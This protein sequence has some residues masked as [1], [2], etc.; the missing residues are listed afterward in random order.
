MRCQH[1]C[2]SKINKGARVLD[3][4]VLSDLAG[5]A[6]ALAVTQFAISGGE[7][8][9]FH[10]L[11]AIVNAIDP[12]KF[13]ISLDSNGWLLT[14]DKAQWL[15]D[16]GVGKVHIS[17]DSA[18]PHTH[19]A[20]RRTSGSYERAVAAITN[21]KNAGLIVNVN[22]VVTKQRVYAEEF[23]R[24]LTLVEDL[25]ATTGLLFAKPLGEWEGNFDILL[26]DADI[27]YTKELERTYPVCSHLSQSYGMDY[28]CRAV[29]QQ[30]AITRYGDVQPCMAIL[31]SLGNIFDEPMKDILDRGMSFKCFSEYT[32]TCL[33]CADKDFVKMY[34][35]KTRGKPQPLSYR[36]FFDLDPCQASHHHGNK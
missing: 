29:K 19:D 18:D 9:L 1:C 27:A 26:D 33:A 2:V 11:E 21:A 16:I 12:N 4:F 23:I 7:P 5:Q 34:S 15:K 17:L 22:T 8:L 6:D 13:F 31:I 14:A 36:N 28:G 35:E 3:P 30:L 10:D 24:F 25:G 32:P 20:F